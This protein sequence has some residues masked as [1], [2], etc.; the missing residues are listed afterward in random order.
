MEE[1]TQ[2]KWEKNVHQVDL[3]GHLNDVFKYIRTKNRFWKTVIY[4]NLAA[5][6][7]KKEKL[8]QSDKWMIINKMSTIFTG[9]VL[10]N[11]VAQMKGKQAQQFHC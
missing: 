11:D 2:R 4:L 7:S 5:S 1:R 3:R 10:F 8:E 6:I 9:T